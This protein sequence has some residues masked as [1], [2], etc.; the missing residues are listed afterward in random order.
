MTQPFFILRSLIVPVI[1][2]EFFRLE[3]WFSFIFICLLISFRQFSYKILHGAVQYWRNRNFVS[4]R[5][6]FVGIIEHESYPWRTHGC[7]LRIRHKMRSKRLHEIR[8]YCKRSRERIRIGWSAEV[9]RIFEFCARGGS[10]SGTIRNEFVV[11]PT[12]H[13]VII[14]KIK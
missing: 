2:K 1:S 11:F 12:N 10:D 5:S 14:E 4:I 7:G 6:V 3:I 8:K 13:V 9:C